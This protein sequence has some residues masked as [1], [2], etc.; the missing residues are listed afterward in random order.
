M[1]SGCNKLGGFIFAP[2]NKIAEGNS[3]NQEGYKNAYTINQ[4]VIC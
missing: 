3:P 2:L 4:K 1:G